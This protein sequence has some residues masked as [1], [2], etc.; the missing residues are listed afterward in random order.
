MAHA[1]RDEQE[2]IIS[3]DNELKEWHFYSDY[4]PHCRKWKH[5][6]T[7]TRKLVEDDGRI[8]LL[9]GAVNGNVILQKKFKR[10]LT[11]EQRLAAANR[12]RN[13]LRR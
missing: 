9:E 12:A 5:L 7:A 1:S 10:E 4:P 8:I 6:V 11:E 3:Y 2:T 13:I